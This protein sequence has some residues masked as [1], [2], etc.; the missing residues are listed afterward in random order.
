[1]ATAAEVFRDYVTDGVPSS[2]PQKVKKSEIRALLGGYERLIN[3]GGLGG[4]TWKSTLSALNADLAHAAGS[5]AVVYEDDIS[6]NNGMYVKAGGSGTGSWSQ[7]TTFLPG[8]QFVTA[9]DDGDSTANAYS[10]D[11]NPRL[12]AGDGVALVEFV[13][14]ATNTSGTVT[15]SF[16]GNPPLTIKTASGNDPAIGGLI[17][18]MPVS[19]VKIGSSFYMRSDQASSAVQAAV[20]AAQGYA[21]EWAQS[22][23]PISVEA[24]GDGAA[25]RSAKYWAAQ[26][27][28]INWEGDYSASTTYS[29]NDGVTFGGSSWRYINASSSVGNSPPSPPTT[30]NSYWRLIAGGG[31]DGAPGGGLK[32]IGCTVVD[33]A[34]GNPS[35]AYEAGDTVNGVVLVAGDVVL[36]AT[37]GGNAADGVYAV[38]PSGG[39]VRHSDFNTWAEIYGGLFPVANGSLWQNVNGLGG[40]LGVTP[41]VFS[42]IS[43]TDVFS[44]A[45]FKVADNADPTKA[46]A[47]QVSGVSAGSTRTITVGDA[48]VTL[49]PQG[50]ERIAAGAV[51]SLSSLDFTNLSAFR[52]LR[53]KGTLFPANDAVNLQLRTSTNNG[54]AYD[55]G[56]GFYA[57]QIDAIEGTTRTVALLNGASAAAFFISSGAG[58]GNDN[59]ECI[60]FTVELSNFNVAEFCAI[61][62]KATLISNTGTIVLCDNGG[63]RSNAVA[64]NA[65]RVLF[66]SGNIARGFYLLEGARI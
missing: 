16:D 61:R 58:V 15:I 2:G 25:D 9:T 57:E 56:S 51:T 37:P 13:V 28:G 59:N 45:A 31:A 64:R 30:S 52:Y 24:G 47:F 40:T 22:D 38:Q 17:E 29:L 5:L 65:F 53:L 60:D 48:D 11:T 41:L 6:A 34:A 66:S 7:I 35:T 43:R 42:D 32:G 21:Q 39:A 12:P 63:F 50:L 14:P 54:G 62:S 1:M 33:T 46:V 8:Y 36:R 3:A 10:M 26:A 19:G 20:E 4:A 18:G 44:D 23:D 27:V 55:T 49:R